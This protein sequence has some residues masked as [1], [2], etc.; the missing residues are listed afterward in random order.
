MRFSCIGSRECAAG[1]EAAAV[2][3]RTA[4][5]RLRLA[6]T[7]REAGWNALR[8]GIEVEMARAQVDS[9]RRIAG[10]VARRALAAER[11]MDDKDAEAL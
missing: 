7:W 5:A 10:D 1:D 9:A 11:L 8:A 2:E 4:A 6:G 3:S